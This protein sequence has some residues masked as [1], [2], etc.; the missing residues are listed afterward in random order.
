MPP[1]TRPDAITRAQMPASSRSNPAMPIILMIIA[2]LIFFFLLLIF[3]GI[4]PLEVIKGDKIEDKRLDTALNQSEQR[5]MTN[6]N[7]TGS[8]YPVQM[9]PTPDPILSSLEKPF[10][11][12]E[13]Q[14]EK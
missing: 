4:I 8:L 1:K 7:T 2:T 5:A 10:M 6:L 11:A 3:I 12:E 13:E 9:A 14:E